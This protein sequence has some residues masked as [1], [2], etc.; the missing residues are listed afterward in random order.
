MF[1]RQL[2]K[3]FRLAVGPMLGLLVL[4]YFAYHALHG[5]RGVL[6]WLR[7][8]NEIQKAEAMLAESSA[9]RSALERRSR[10][11]RSNSIDPDL[12]DERVRAVLNV[13]RPDEIIVLLQDR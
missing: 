8:Q 12:L 4:G 9:V 5:E 2:R 6:A 11:L 10:L 7:L 1:W 13:G 3:R